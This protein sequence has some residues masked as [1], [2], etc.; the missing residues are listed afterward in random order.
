M[1]RTIFIILCTF[2]ALT[3]SAQH[4]P[5]RFSPEK[6]QQ[7]MEQYIVREARLTPQEASKFLPIFAEMHQKQRAVYKRQ[8]DLWKRNLNDD[9]TCREVVKQNDALDLELKK[10]Q[11]Q[12]HEK[13]LNVIPARK[14]LDVIHA[15][16]R[17]HRDQ[18]KKWGKHRP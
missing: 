2:C 5:W 4:M 13:F 3:L 16:N 8:R 14:V 7:D 1:K 6:F 15:E 18:L 17:F 10:L 11:Q 9:A 12:Y